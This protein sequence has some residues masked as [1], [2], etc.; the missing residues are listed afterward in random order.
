MQGFWMVFADL[1]LILLLA[2]LLPVTAIL[3]V[4]GLAIWL[5]VR[6]RSE[7]IEGAMLPPAIPPS[8][9]L[10]EQKVCAIAESVV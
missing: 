8:N 7:P 1:P 10:G 3:L 9:T 5:I 2:T 4:L 6:P